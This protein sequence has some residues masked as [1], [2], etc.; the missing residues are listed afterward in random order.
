MGRSQMRHESYNFNVILALFYKL[1]YHVFLR[2]FLRVFFTLL[3]TFI[4]IFSRLILERLLVV[5]RQSE[6]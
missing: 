5:H 4:N 6:H 1:F 3:Y 2:V